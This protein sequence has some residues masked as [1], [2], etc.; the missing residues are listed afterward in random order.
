M[1]RGRATALALALVLV[2]PSAGKAAEDP[3]TA[4]APPIVE[5]R[6]VGVLLQ[7]GVTVAALLEAGLDVVEVDGGS[8]LLLEWPGDAERLAG[9]GAAARLVD[10]HPGRSAAA[11]TRA[12][13]ASRPRPAPAR[14]WSAAREDGI[15]RAEALP[16]FGSG[17]LGGFWTLAEVKMKLDQLVA[18]DVNGVVAAKLD[19]LGLSVQGRPIWG[20]RLGTTVAPPDTRPVALLNALT[21]AREPEGMQA[22]LYFVDD[23]LGRY[24]SDPFATYLLEHRVTYVVPVVNPDGYQRNQDIYVAS[25]SFGLWRK[26]LRDNDGSG[27]VTSADGVDLNRN[28]GF[29]WGHNNVGSSGSPGSSTYRGPAAFSEPET[30]AQRD[31]VVGLRPRS[32]IS[33]HTYGDL[34]LHPW[35][36]TV[37]AARDSAAFYEWDDDMSLGSGYQTGQATRVLYEVNGEFNDWCYG[38]TLLKP[39][40]FTWTPEV[41]GP[42]DGFWPPPSR[43]L[44]L[45]EEN[46]RGCWYAAAI[47][48][49]HVRIEKATILGGTGT[50]DP[51]YSARIVVRARNRGASGQAGPGLTATLVPLSGGAWVLEGTVAYPALAPFESADPVDGGSFRV[52]ADDTVK[53]GSILRYAVE[54]SAPGGF[55]SRDT[56]EVPCGRPTVLLAD[57]A[58]AGLG[59]WST[60][61]WGIESGDPAHPGPF[62]ADSPGGLYAAS[63]DNTLTAAAPFDLST[64]LHAY[65]FYEA[66]W[67]FQSDHDYG[68]IEA[69]LDGT[70]WT[71]LPAR[72][73]SL[74]MAGVQPAGRRI[75]DGTRHFWGPE[76][77]D[78]SAFAGAGAVRLRFRVR[79]DAGGQFDGLALDSVRVMAFDPAVQPPPVGAGAP[80]PTPALELRRLAPNPMRDRLA[81]ELAVGASGPLRLEVMDLQGRRVRTLADATVAGRASYRHEWDG[82]DQSGR[83][84]GAGVY[85]VRASG[86]GRSL[87]RRIVLIP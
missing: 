82:R 33:F 13:Q 42:G 26:N 32:G 57:G 71:P 6:L 64:A 72:G 49:P 10:E 55:F 51:G 66:R 70:T 29:H 18:D 81:V 41:G 28:Y 11:R 80:H 59:N 87:T 5:P 45:A 75:Y 39:R 61:T 37:Q 52:T 22:L 79:A 35:G 67:D 56:V 53:A 50:L 76:R 63:A 20:L 31:L 43:I 69:S 24:G 46:L 38:D 16:P 83:R 25:G 30:R 17:S 1:T 19:T 74:G 36:W 68:S 14:V 85:L 73:S 60:T 23:L 21:H 15:F 58:A 54:F 44:P 9:L 3:K 48:G 86:N 7:A 12:E 27:T 8:A 62:F 34:L 77:A 47:A 84:V 65:V 2:A 40:A 78:L 4:P